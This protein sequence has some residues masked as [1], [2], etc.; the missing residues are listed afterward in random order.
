MLA[1]FLQ[2]TLL[3]VHYSDHQ[4]L[5]LVI[6][7]FYY[8]I[9]DFFMSVDRSKPEPVYNAMFVFQHICDVDFAMCVVPV[10]NVIL[11][12]CMRVL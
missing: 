5:H 10:R 3:Q 11:F 6:F 8:R 7:T 2:P 12:C 9:V 4:S 1:F